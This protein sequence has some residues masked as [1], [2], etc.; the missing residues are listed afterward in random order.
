MTTNGYHHQIAARNQI[1][2]PTI[3]GGNL[4]YFNHKTP[5][6]IQSA[7]TEAIIAKDVE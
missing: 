7:K 6:G 1:T 2:A 5:A 3:K 4:R